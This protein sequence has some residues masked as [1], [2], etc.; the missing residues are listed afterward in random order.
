MP[1]STVSYMELAKADRLPKGVAL[2]PI[3]C[4]VSASSKIQDKCLALLSHVFCTQLRRDVDWVW[5]SCRE[6]RK[7]FGRH[8]SVVVQRCIDSGVLEYNDRYKW[9]QNHHCKNFRI[10]REWMAHG[11]EARLLEFTGLGI[12]YW[13][14]D[15]N[16]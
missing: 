11:M 6:L 7:M 12:T 1:I 4:D 16:E 8:Y 13:L 10:N 2:V 15:K 9:A 14:E 5:M 3:G